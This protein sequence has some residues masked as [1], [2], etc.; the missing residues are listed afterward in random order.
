MELFKAQALRFGTRV[1]TT[2]VTAVDLSRGR[3][4]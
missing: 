3:S 1:R 2:D 4:R